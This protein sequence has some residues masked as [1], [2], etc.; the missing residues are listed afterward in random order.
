[1][2]A[3]GHEHDSGLIVCQARAAVMSFRKLLGLLTSSRLVSSCFSTRSF[4]LPQAKFKLA[5]MER[6]LAQSLAAIKAAPAAA[7][8]RDPAAVAQAQAAAQNVRP[9]RLCK[10][11]LERLNG[12][13]LHIRRAW[14]AMWEHYER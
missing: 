12:F 4:P 10:T 7:I 8:G 14:T 5:Y 11:S 3:P 2:V 13:E 6:L 9:E 1:M